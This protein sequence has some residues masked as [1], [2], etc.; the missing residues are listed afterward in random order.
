[1]HLDLSVYVCV[2]VCVCVHVCLC[3]WVDVCGCVHVC[4]H[5][6]T[7]IYVCRNVCT[8]PHVHMSTLSCACIHDCIHFTLTCIYLHLHTTMHVYN[9]TSVVV[10]AHMFVDGWMFQ[11]GS[12]HH[13]HIYC[14]T[15]IFLY[16][17]DCWQWSVSSYMLLKSIN[18]YIPIGCVLF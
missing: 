7:W 5:T 12:L 4:M 15:I 10:D 11:P 2:Y 14:N 3:G 17:C 9:M 8:H 6:C 1:M 18:C 16:T 13:S